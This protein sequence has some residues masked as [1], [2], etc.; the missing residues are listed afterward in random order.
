MTYESISHSPTTG[1][2]EIKSY[3]STF[4]TATV[5]LEES[6]FTESVDYVNSLSSSS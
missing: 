5:S 4:D 2:D 6:S 3:E 1:L